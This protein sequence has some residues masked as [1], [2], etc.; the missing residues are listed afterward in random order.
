MGL[1]PLLLTWKLGAVDAHRMLAQQHSQEAL[2]Q[3]NPALACRTRAQ[4]LR[5]RVCKPSLLRA[6]SFGRWNREAEPCW[7]DLEQLSHLLR[8]PPRQ[9]GG[10]GRRTHP[11]HAQTTLLW[12]ATDPSVS[13]KVNAQQRCPPG[14]GSLLN[15]RSLPPETNCSSTI[16]ILWRL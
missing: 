4:G 9:R 10:K 5:V 6:A 3:Q 7:A 1:K 2:T 8:R 16:A 11:P 13:A 12:S 14:E 15:P